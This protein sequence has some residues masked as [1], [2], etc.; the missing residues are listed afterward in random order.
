MTPAEIAARNRVNARRSTGP[1]TKAGKAI[2]AK[3][4]RRH[5]ATA[6]PAPDQVAT[7]IRILLNAPGL[8]ASEFTPDR[9]DITLTVALAEA[10]ARYASAQRAMRDF[11]KSLEVL[12]PS[13]KRKKRELIRTLTQLFTED[14][15]DAEEK[16]SDKA[17]ATYVVKALE[18]QSSPRG[19]HYRLLR[20]YLTEARACRNKAF[21]AWICF[22]QEK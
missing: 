3:N 6:K 16:K 17:L 18:D 15:A 9:E 8:E 14:D 21:D 10:E 22:A 2:V 20:R 5:G 19:R 1:R 13:D 7:W 4:A 12:P 11:E